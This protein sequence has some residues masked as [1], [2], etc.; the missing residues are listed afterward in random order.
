MPN[1]R[2]QLPKD[3]QPQK[4]QIKVTDKRIFTAEGEVREEFRQD[5]KPADPNAK[6]AERPAPKPEKPQAPP[7]AK[8]VEGNPTGQER[9]RT[10]ADRAA[11]P[12]TPF[13]NFIEPL[14]AQAYMNLGM[15]RNPYQPQAKIDASAARQMIE[16]ISLLEG[17]TKGNLTPEEDDFLSTH[18]GE[19]KLAYVQRT[20]NI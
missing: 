13:S 7:A 15:L 4:E 11:N 10:L 1:R 5:I 8:P 12:G 3:K 17:K 16:I 19:L 14:I 2:Q 18:L 20:K 6:P 9:R